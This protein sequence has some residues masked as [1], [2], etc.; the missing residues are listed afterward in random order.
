MSSTS[1]SRDED[2]A[3]PLAPLSARAVPGGQRW[4]AVGTIAAVIG[5]VVAGASAY[6][7]KPGDTLYSIAG[8]NDTTVQ[9]LANANGIS[10]PNLILVGQQLEITRSA[11]GPDSQ[12]ATNQAA[13]PASGEAAPA[14]A[15][16]PSLGSTGNP[17]DKRVHVVVAGE[18]VE[19]IARHYGIP[20][21][22]FMAANGLTNR[23]QLLRGARVQMAAS[24][25]A[26][27]TG[28][29]S[30]GTY[31]IKA[32][33]TLLGIASSQGVSVR[34][35]ASSNGLANANMIV[36][37]QRLDIPGN[38]AGYVCP[39]PGSSFIN[40]W[41]VRKPDGRFHQGVDMMAPVGTPIVAPT[42]GSLTQIDGTRGGLQFRLDGDD[43][44]VHFGSHMDSFG[45][46]GR[47]SA[48]EVIGT[49]GTSGNARGGPAHLHYS[50]RLGDGLINPY[51]SLT[52][53]C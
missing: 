26:P 20:I 37:G 3:R 28:S 30:G 23:N 25:P 24:G 49:V 16:V 17:N 11:N 8:R 51:P 41:G 43:G 36:V 5:M 42:S 4:K 32:G 38:A 52:A 31:T 34:E 45:A 1:A 46:A 44:Y 7:V 15:P 47:V 53:T 29:T 48:G 18:S 19:S 50:V 40:D 14:G 35:L 39:V 27:G 2:P 9:A 10:N 6:T 12:P 22:Q 13:A 21:E 33:D